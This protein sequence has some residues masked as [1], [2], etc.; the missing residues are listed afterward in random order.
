[1]TRAR[2]HTDIERDLILYAYLIGDP[3]AAIA[4]AAGRS[5]STVSNVASRAGYARSEMTV[6][7]RRKAAAAALDRLVAA[8]AKVE[9]RP[10]RAL[11][12]NAELTEDERLLILRDWL[13]GDAVAEIARNVGKAKGIVRRVVERVDR[14][15][16]NDAGRQAAVEQHEKALAALGVRVRPRRIC[17]IHV[18]RFDAGGFRR[19]PIDPRDDREQSPEPLLDP[20]R[21]RPPDRKGEPGRDGRPMIV[22]AREEFGKVVT[23]RNIAASPIDH[24]LATGGLHD[25]RKVDA[26]DLELEAARGAAMRR[27]ETAGWLE[28]LFRRAEIG[29]VSAVDL[30]K[31]RVDGGRPMGVTTSALDAQERI[32]RV[33]ARI[34]R[35]AFALLEAVIW[36]EGVNPVGKGPAKRALRQAICHALD[37]AAVERGTLTAAQYRARWPDGAPALESGPEGAE[38]VRGAS[39]APRSTRG[40]SPP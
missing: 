23:A 3:L 16:M 4:K 37:H 36:R 18:R 32:G 17:S 35:D 2:E 26:S 12:G 20:S 22:A 27:H 5:V 6:E 28:G 34:G 33:H 13:A 7:A 9:P 8:G 21:P 40:A 19:V 11:S 1:M 24:M 14:G 25:P 39:P 38:S 15:V 31:V 29:D 30:D 10:V